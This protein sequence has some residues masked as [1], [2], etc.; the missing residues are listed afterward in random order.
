MIKYLENR[1]SLLDKLYS[2]S[3][4]EVYTPLSL[5]NEI[6]D[7]LPEE[8][9]DNYDLKWLNPAVK[10]G[11]FLG[12]I[13]LRLIKNYI[14]KGIFSIEQ[15]AYN[16]IIQN[17]IYGYALS[18]G[19][20]RTANKLVYGSA[21]YN[22]NIIHANILE[23]QIDM[24]FDVVI[25]NPPYQNNSDSKKIANRGATRNLY[26]KFIEK[27]FNIL[28]DGGTISFI[29]PPGFLKSTEWGTP[30]KYYKYFT[31][32][33]FQYLKLQGVKKKYFEQ[34]TPICYWIVNKTK[35]PENLTEIDS[36][37]KVYVKNHETFFIPSSL[38]KHTFNIFEKVANAENSISLNF[39][40]ERE[41]PKEKYVA[42]K[43]MNNRIHGMRATPMQDNLS[44][45]NDL[46]FRTK[47]PESIAKI[48]NSDIFTYLIR[49]VQYDG[50]IYFNFIN[51]LKIP[52]NLDKEWTEDELYNF[53]GFNEDEINSIKN[54]GI[55]FI[56]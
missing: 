27:G 10:N 9:W 28:K 38:D 20:L 11:V 15:E 26:Q 22:G 29:T 24:K 1:L 35:N 41:Y 6:L 5:T 19:A 56:E 8:V 46:I 40:R 53:Y 52:K 37:E 30:N 36:V 55:V 2:P 45:G 7:K 47:Y 16:H 4:K 51:G 33:D 34:A 50:L 12:A 54:L 48:L 39:K 25:G 21:K 18:R 3:N 14:E 44:L 49:R 31:E 42:V 23:E 43:A 17:Q 13:T 32:Y